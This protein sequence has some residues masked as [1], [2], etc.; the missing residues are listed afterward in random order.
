MVEFYKKYNP[1][2]V[3]Q[4]GA[5]LKACEGN[6]PE[7]FAGLPAKYISAVD[8]LADKKGCPTCKKP[9]KVHSTYITLA[10]KKKKAASAVE[11]D[12]LY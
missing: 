6:E 5:I 1:A 4:V 7:F 3:E 8:P 2:K 12:E 9:V 10:P 11:L